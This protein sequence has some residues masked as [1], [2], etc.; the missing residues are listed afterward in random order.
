ME[1]TAL[2]Q[3]DRALRVALQTNGVQR[4][5]TRQMSTGISISHA[6]QIKGKE[7]NAVLVCPLDVLHEIGVPVAVQRDPSSHVLWVK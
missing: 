5:S 7:A 4:S 3:K 1:S 2:F 6:F